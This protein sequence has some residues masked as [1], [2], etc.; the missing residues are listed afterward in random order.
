MKNP[1]VENSL[2]KAL[3]YSKYRTL[4]KELLSQGKATGPDQNQSRL[5]F[6]KLN[7]RRMDRLDKTL[8]VLPTTQERLTKLNEEFT[9]LVIAEG[10][11]GDAAQVLPIVNKISE[12]SDL[13]NMKVVLRDEN[14]E[15]MDEFLTNGSRSIPKVI[16]L[17]KYK[18]VVDSWGPRPSIASKMVAEYK[19]RHGK[20]DEAIKKDLQIWYNK[21]KG[22]NTQDDILKLLPVD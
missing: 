9:M 19:R 8:K 17:D 21:D 10:W 18:N 7:D 11:C 20:V 14:E 6:S 5:D 16:I 1:I 12:S 4:V 3:T 13:V 2:E 15:L 22:S